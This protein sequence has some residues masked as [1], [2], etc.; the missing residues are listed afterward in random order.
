MRESADRVR[1][2]HGIELPVD[3]AWNHFS[4]LNVVPAVEEW[5]SPANRAAAAA[6]DG[7]VP[8][9]CDGDAW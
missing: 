6:L 2:E 9:C 7:E 8:S 5:H 1:R 4:E 3:D